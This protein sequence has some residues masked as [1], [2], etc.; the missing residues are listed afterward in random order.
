ML[1]NIHAIK[2]FHREI[3]IALSSVLNLSYNITK[4]FLSLHPKSFDKVVLE[5]L[6][7]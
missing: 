1:G 7:T 6:A 4:A 3:N 2:I 5:R